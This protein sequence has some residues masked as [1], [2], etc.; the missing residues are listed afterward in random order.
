[1]EELEAL[2][3]DYLSG[4]QDVWC[5]MAHCYNNVDDWKPVALLVEQHGQKKL[6]L[7]WLAKFA[8]H[9]A[10][11][12]DGICSSRHGDWSRQQKKDMKNGKVPYKFLDVVFYKLAYREDRAFVLNAPTNPSLT[13]LEASQCHHLIYRMAFFCDVNVLVSWVRAFCGKRTSLRIANECAEVVFSACIRRNLFEYIKMMWPWFF[14][15]RGCCL[16]LRYACETKRNLVR[17]AFKSCSHP[18]IVLWFLFNVYDKVY[19]AHLLT[20]KWLSPISIPLV[21]RF[22]DVKDCSRFIAEFNQ[23]I[24]QHDFAKDVEKWEAGFFTLSLLA[25]EDSELRSLV[26][27][28]IKL[29]AQNLGPHIVQLAY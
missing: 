23:R 6:P 18:G 7:W 3:W 8:K 28:T 22:Y 25:V 24:F 2:I 16:S 14:G 15:E 20:G 12:Y 1:M 27:Q 10:C 11:T 21:S 13:H 5:R 26:N 19:P 9:R 4:W 17:V 29:L